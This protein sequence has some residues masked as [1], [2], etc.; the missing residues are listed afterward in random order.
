LVPKI[1][2]VAETPPAEVRRQAEDTVLEQAISNLEEARRLPP[3]LLPGQLTMAD[4]SGLEL[5]SKVNGAAG[6]LEVREDEDADLD[7]VA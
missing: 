6:M 7:D 4:M 1:S 5:S 2:E 3:P